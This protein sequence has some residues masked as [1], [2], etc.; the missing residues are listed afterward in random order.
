MNYEYEKYITDNDNIL[1]TLNKY[2]VAIIPD[3]INQQECDAVKQ[4]MWDYLETITAKLPVPIKKDRT[5]TWTSYKELYPKHSML[6]KH[7]SIGHAQFIWN[8]RTNHKVIEPFEKIWNVSKEELLVSF[9]GASFHIPPEITSFGWAAKK[10]K[11]WLHTDQSYLRNDFECVQGWINAYDTNE[12]DA[13]LIV[14]ERSHKYHGDFAKEFEE[15]SPDDWFLL[16]QEQIKWYTDTKKCVKKMIKC[17]A[18]SLVL[19]D[20]RTIHCAKEPEI[21]RNQPNYRCVVYLCYTPRSFASMG[22][23][24]TKINAWKNLRTTSHWPHNPQL[25]DL[26]PNTFGNP[27]PQIVQIVKPEIDDLAYSLIGY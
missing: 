23:L 11:L 16:N 22:M 8:L 6:L 2:G 26:Y 27:L 4:G 1:D 7:W 3:I 9:D 25:C 18:G 14:L 13:T 12:G 24:N 19:W 17:P 10:D 15:T 21:K 20:S 5:S